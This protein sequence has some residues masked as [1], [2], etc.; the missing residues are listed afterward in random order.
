MV[1]FSNPDAG[2][3]SVGVLSFD[4][5]IPCNDDVHVFIDDVI[6][7]RIRTFLIRT[8]DNRSALLT[9]FRLQRLELILDESPAPWFVFQ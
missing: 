1:T 6:L 3:L 8:C 9:K 7:D 4:P 5:S 2:K